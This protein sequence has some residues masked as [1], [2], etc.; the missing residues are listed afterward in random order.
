MS[1]DLAH[2]KSGDKFRISARTYNAWCDAARQVLGEQH[3]ISSSFSS[4]SSSSGI[5]LV[6]NDSGYALSRYR[7]VG[8]EALAISPA[9]NPNDMVLSVVLPNHELH[10]GKW[11]VL[12]EPLAAGAIG[13]AVI[14]GVTYL[15]PLSAILAEHEY[16]DVDE[17]N[18]VS[19]A[20]SG[21]AQLLWYEKPDDFPSTG[22]AIV[23]LGVPTKGEPPLDTTG[24]TENMVY[25]LRLYG[26]L[27]MPVWDYMMV[28]P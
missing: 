15:S 19:T 6:R 25:Q 27:M 3:N 18:G 10:E 28:H 26:A 2:V 9:D 21:P 22:W 4:A 12:Q 7:A 14:S 16:V 20:Y 23:K 11:C 5:V 8:I 17:L 13:K 1:D 24:L